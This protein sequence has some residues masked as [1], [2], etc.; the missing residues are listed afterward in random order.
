MVFPL[1]GMH[2]SLTANDEGLRRLIDELWR[3]TICKRA[4][5][6]SGRSQKRLDEG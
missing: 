4:N 3:E 6:A 5:Q 2:G 1:H